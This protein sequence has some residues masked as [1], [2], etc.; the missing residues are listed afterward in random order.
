MRYEKPESFFENYVFKAH[1]A[2]SYKLYSYLSLCY[3]Q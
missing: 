3:D 2:Q 1:M